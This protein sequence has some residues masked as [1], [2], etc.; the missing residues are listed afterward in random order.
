MSVVL[1]VHVRVDYGYANDVCFNDLLFS[2]LQV[3]ELMGKISELESGVNRHQYEASE[4]KVTYHI[5]LLNV[6]WMIASIFL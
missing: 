6:A 3:E 4:L 5:V 2:T 1:Y